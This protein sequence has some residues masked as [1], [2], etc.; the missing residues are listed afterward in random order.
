MTCVSF[1]RP[2]PVANSPHRVFTP[3]LNHISL[4][5]P[6][7]PLLSARDRLRPGSL[8]NQTSLA[9]QGRDCDREYCE[10]THVVRV[11]LGGVLEIVLVDQGTYSKL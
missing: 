4:S 8:C 3:Q 9:A 11:P 2:F 1:E 7:F 6:A 10:C 5:L